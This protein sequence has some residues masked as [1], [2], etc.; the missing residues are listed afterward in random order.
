MNTTSAAVLTVLVVTGGQY[1]QGK[2]LSMK[3]LI[4]LGVFAIGLA[5]LS[6]VN[7]ELGKAFGLLVLV[8][9]VLMY[10]RPIAKGLGY[11]K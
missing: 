10:A 2:T 8:T 5:A 11:A 6:E 1:A 4:G 3:I 7:A 9:A